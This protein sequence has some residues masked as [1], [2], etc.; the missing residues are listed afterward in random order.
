[1][2]ATLQ[3]GH[4]EPYSPLVQGINHNADM[5]STPLID[6]FK[7]YVTDNLIEGHD[8]SGGVVR[9]IPM[10]KLEAYWEERKVREI[11]ESHYRGPIFQN[12]ETIRNQYIIVFSILVYIS[13]PHFIDHCVTR[14]RTDHVLPLE[15]RPGNWPDDPASLSIYHDFYENQWKFCPLNFDINKSLHK[16]KLDPRQ[17]IPIDYIQR[18]SQ[19]A[20][21]GDIAIFWKV[22]IHDSCNAL[23]PKVVAPLD[24][25]NG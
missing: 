5:D 12:A 6:G 1:V 4:S 17:V 14:S 16:R 19:S 20:G 25:L 23:V 3:A 22:N 2:L 7:Q 13:Q 11:L 18:L 15:T 10:S 21:D 8:G 24:P 9:Y